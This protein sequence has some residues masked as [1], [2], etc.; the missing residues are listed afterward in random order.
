M[1][2]FFA[3]TTTPADFLPGVLASG[4]TSIEASAMRDA[5]G[6]VLK[7]TD[8]TG[9]RWG[10]ASGIATNMTPGALPWIWSDATMTT[11]APIDTVTTVFPTLSDLDCMGMINMATG[12]HGRDLDGSGT[13]SNTTSNGNAGSPGSVAVDQSAQ[14]F[15]PCQ[16]TLSWRSGSGNNVSRQRLTL[17]AAFGPTH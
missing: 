16:I 9:S 12:A 4:T 13:I 10:P 15:C 6:L 5:R 17:Y 7:M 14:L 2:G 8:E 3:D 11:V 1:S